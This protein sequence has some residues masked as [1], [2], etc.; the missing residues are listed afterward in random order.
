M[1]L[2]LP[3]HVQV[4]KK[5]K[6]ILNLNNY[7][8]AHHFTLNKAKTIYHQL[9]KEQLIG[10]ERF[11]WLQLHYKIYRKDKRKYDGNNVVCIVDK[12]LMDALVEYKVI[13]DDDIN[14]VGYYTWEHCGVDKDNPRV[15]VEEKG[16]R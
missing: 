14:H 13:S 1:K 5:K 8:N 12:F 7:R 4:S 10:Q 16:G 2:I 3:L 15:E 9:V 6:F 11:H